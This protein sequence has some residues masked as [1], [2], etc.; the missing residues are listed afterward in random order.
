MKYGYSQTDR[1]NIDWFEKDM[2][3]STLA[4][5]RLV[6]GRIRSLSS[7]DIDFSYPISVIA[8]RNGTGKSTILALAACAFHNTTKGFRLSGRK[9][10]YYTMSEFFVQSEEEANPAGIRIVYGIRHNNWRRTQEWPDGVRLG[11]QARVKKQGG[12]WSNYGQRV[13]RNVVFFGIERVVP[14]SERSVSRSYRH[15]FARTQDAGFEDEAR[16]IV[17][18]ILGRNYDA[19]WFR[20]HSK[21]RLPHVRTKDG[22]YSGFNMGAGENALFEIFSSILSAPEG[23]LIVVDE[24]E[25]GLHESAQRRLIY[26][27]KELANA[28]K[29]QVICTT[30]SSAILDSVP[31]EG[32]FYLECQGNGTVVIPG[33]APAYAAGM[34]SESN[35]LELDILV[36]DGVSGQLLLSALPASFRRRLSIL[37]IGSAAAVIRQLA[38]RYRASKEMP[39]LAL[40]DGDQRSE[41]CT[42]LRYFL[43]NAECDTADETAKAWLGARLSYLPGDAWPESWVISVLTEACDN[44]IASEFNVPVPDLNIALTNAFCAGKHRE[45]ARLAA[46][47]YL[48]QSDVSKIAC[49]AA[50]RLSPGTVTLILETIQ[51]HLE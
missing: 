40:L 35:S 18:R 11:Y 46:D 5:I 29:L 1:R 44:A 26:E 50:C 37:P 8:G 20:E 2:T 19:F 17:G 28:R 33:I 48:P 51:R 49:R 39:C 36:E 23:L 47:L 27:L 41:G 14:N 16:A 3:R 9:N 15:F 34:L 25:L 13:H 32:R 38:A 6:Q 43:K 22:V 21:Y 45:F 30:H 12:K 31:P 24:I 42:H 7:F 4:S 10:P